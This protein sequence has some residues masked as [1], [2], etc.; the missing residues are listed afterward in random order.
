MPLN[1]KTKQSKV[2]QTKLGLKRYCGLFFFI[3]VIY[4]QLQFVLKYYLMDKNIIFI[5]I[6][7]V[8]VGLVFDFWP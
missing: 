2:N 1:K 6:S 3:V 7:Q 4:N 8:F 5:K